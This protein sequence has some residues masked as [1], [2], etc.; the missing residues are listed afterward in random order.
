MLRLLLLLLL[1]LFQQNPSQDVVVNCWAVRRLYH[2]MAMA[3]PSA[4]ASRL[5]CDVEGERGDGGGDLIPISGTVM[6]SRMTWVIAWYT[7]DS[8]PS[9]KEVTI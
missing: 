3:R 5:Q 4:V 9:C 8:F 7:C 1:L 6:F 2:S